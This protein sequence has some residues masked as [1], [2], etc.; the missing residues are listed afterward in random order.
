MKAAFAFFPAWPLAGRA[1]D[2]V[3]SSAEAAQHATATT[4]LPR[5][6]ANVLVVLKVS[7]R[8]KHRGGHDCAERALTRRAAGRRARRR[9]GPGPCARRSSRPG[10]RSRR[11]RTRTARRRSR[12]APRRCRSCRSSRG[13]PRGCCSRRGGCGACRSRPRRR[14]S[15]AGAR[16]SSGV[17]PEEEEDAREL[18]GRDPVEPREPGAVDDPRA[19]ERDAGD[20][21]RSRRTTA[22][23]AVGRALALHLGADLL[24]HHLG[25]EVV[26]V[27][28]HQR[29]DPGE[30]VRVDG[31]ERDR[32]RAGRAQGR[33]AGVHPAGRGGAGRRAPRRRAPGSARGAGR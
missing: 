11:A 1:A 5:P 2:E 8:L 4:R 15:R 30:R 19:G 29:E 17:V 20:R 18:A 28:V 26:A 9:S 16:R 10:R 13:R 21:L 3:R 27:G 33:V 31:G 25:R 24:Q 23:P 7:G 22:A 14:A 32:V 12:R 6:S